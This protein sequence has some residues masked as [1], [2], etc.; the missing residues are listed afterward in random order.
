MNIIQRSC[1][2]TVLTLVLYLGANANVKTDINENVSVIPASSIEIGQP[3]QATN[4]LDVL[5]TIISHEL[6][7]A[8]LRDRD[9]IDAK[10]REAGYP[11]DRSKVQRKIAACSIAFKWLGEQCIYDWDES[12]RQFVK[13]AV[14]GKSFNGGGGGW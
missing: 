2:F 9:V 11:T 3:A 5:D 6:T 7:E 12:T 1:T 10:R 4:W 13:T 8:Y 14:V